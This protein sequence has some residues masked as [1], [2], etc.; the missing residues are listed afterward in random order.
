MTLE[1]KMSNKTKRS[2]IYL[3]S[4]IYQAIRLKAVETETSVSS[5]VSEA[6]RQYLL[7]DAEDLAAF[8]ERAHEK[9]ISFE[10]ALKKLKKDGRL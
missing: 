2:T 4:G 3:D 1:A 5:I 8:E 6:V 9:G 7:E 10:T